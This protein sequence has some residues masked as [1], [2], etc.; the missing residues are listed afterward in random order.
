MLDDDDESWWVVQLLSKM[1][2][3]PGLLSEGHAAALARARDR[4]LW[5][6][7]SD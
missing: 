2:G 6:D 1:E 4:A 3:E 5:G 7:N